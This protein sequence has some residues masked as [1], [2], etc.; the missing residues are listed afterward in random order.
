MADS[1]EDQ[2]RLREEQF[3]V[4]ML[5]RGDQETC[6]GQVKLEMPICHLTE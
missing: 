4:G 5:G 3:A 1:T 2:E 6:F